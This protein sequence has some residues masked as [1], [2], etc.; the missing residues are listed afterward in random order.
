[1]RICTGAFKRTPTAAR[2]VE[3]GE[4]PLELRRTQVALIYWVNLQDHSEEHP[5]QE[6]LLPCW[7]KER[8]ETRSCGWTA[9][10]KAKEMNIDKF[11]YS[12]TVSLPATAPW[13]TD[14]SMDDIYDT[15]LTPK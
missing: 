3:M 9:A 6:T 13:K 11:N 5:A 12:Q 1:M 7:E 10:P 4:M 14:T 2:Q 15:Q 8:R